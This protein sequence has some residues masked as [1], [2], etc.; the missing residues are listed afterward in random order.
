MKKTIENILD[1]IFLTSL[2]VGLVPLLFI[3]WLPI[4]ESILAFRVLITC[5]LTGFISYVLTVI[6]DSN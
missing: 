6:I 4:L 2:F 5:L 3:I 1:I